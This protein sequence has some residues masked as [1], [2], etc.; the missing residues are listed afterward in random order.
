MLIPLAPKLF[1]P[2]LMSLQTHSILF[3]VLALELVNVFIL[4]NALVLV[5]LLDASPG[6]S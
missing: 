4:E 1:L 6:V 3:L 2:V 5:T